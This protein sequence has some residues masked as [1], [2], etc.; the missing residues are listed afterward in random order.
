MSLNLTAAA[1][2]ITA[3]FQT[4]TLTLE[5]DGHTYT[6]A[7][8][9]GPQSGATRDEV[10]ARV[11][12][13]DYRLTLPAG[14]SLVLKAGEIVTIDSRRYRV[15]WAPAHGNLWLTDRYGVTEVR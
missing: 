8:G 13:G 5:R 7:C 2:T 15:V 9:L 11:E 14:S 1:A 12:R 10:A 3:L 6:A 4:R